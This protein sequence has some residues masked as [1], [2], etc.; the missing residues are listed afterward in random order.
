MVRALQRLR[1]LAPEGETTREITVPPAPINALLTAALR[2]EAA[3]LRRA[4]V[5]FGSSLLCL[6][7]KREN[8]EG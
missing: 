3:W 8:A 7:R 5:P 2:A 6:A 1:G 4:D